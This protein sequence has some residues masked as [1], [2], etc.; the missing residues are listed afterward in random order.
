LDWYPTHTD[1][2]VLPIRTGSKTH[3]I[4]SFHANT[5][6]HKYTASNENLPAQT[7]SYT[8]ANSNLKNENLN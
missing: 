3:T 8:K 7:D 2:Y 6:I 1:I 5:S 4:R